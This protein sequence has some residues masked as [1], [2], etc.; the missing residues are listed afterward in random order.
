MVTTL[1]LALPQRMLRWQS[2]FVDDLD[3]LLQPALREQVDAAAAARWMDGLAQS[4]GRASPLA[5]ALGINFMSYLPYDLLVKSDRAA[6]LHSLELRSPFLDTAL[7]EYVTALPDSMKRRGLTTKWILRRAFRDLVPRE[8]QRRAKMGFGIPLGRWFRTGLR[9]YLRD[10]FAP[11]ARLY[12]YVRPDVVLRLLEEHETGLHDHE[13]KIWLLI[14]MERWLQLFPAW[15][16][17]TGS[18]PAAP[19]APVSR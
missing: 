18:R 3:A 12:E 11:S 4:C 10:T 16:Q 9:G 7:V 1:S 17:S 14:T 5:T 15:C 8:I 2:F 6:M 13:Y 19:V